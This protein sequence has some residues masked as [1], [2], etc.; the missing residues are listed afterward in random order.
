[1]VNSR[2]SE[3]VKW[4]VEEGRVNGRVE[5]GMVNALME[6]IWLYPVV[7]YEIVV[8]FLYGLKIAL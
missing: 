1:M 5:Y 6:E 2:H 7:P 4:R 3:R 8:T